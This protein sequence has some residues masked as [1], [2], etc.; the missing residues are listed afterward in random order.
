MFPSHPGFEGSLSLAPV[1][2]DSSASNV[3]EAHTPGSAASEAR[4]TLYKRPLDL[5]ILLAAH[6]A[7]APVFLVLWAVIPLL[8]WVEDRG[9]VF[10][11]QHRPG[12]GGRLFTILKFRTMVV[13]AD[14]IGPAWTQDKD[15]RVTRVGKVLRRTA[16]DELP[17]IL[18]IWKGDM[19]FVG[20]R[21]LPVK[22]QQLL[23]QQIPGFAG[24]LNVRPGLT[25]MAQVYDLKDEAPTKLRY[26]L[27]YIRCMNL[28]LDV[29]LILMSARNTLMGRWDVRTGKKGME[30]PS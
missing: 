10:Y 24:R 29:K 2:S 9:P 13:N 1:V 26:D 25:G 5:A 8:V 21:A 27:E 15:P 30:K 12:K 11:R 17:S 28:L 18:S 14:K 3:S 19:S 22:E 23:E 16:L 6:L 4:G 20:P 7:L